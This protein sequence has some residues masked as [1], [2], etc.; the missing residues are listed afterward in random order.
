MLGTFQAAMQTPWRDQPPQSAED[1]LLWLR[2]VSSLVMRSR[3]DKN[4]G[5]WKH[6][7]NQTGAT[8]FVRPQFVQGTLLKGF[9]C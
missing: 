6:Q 8:R 7:N 2:N 4:P 3:Q 9:E 1:F 5:K